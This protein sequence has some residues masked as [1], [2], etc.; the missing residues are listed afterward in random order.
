MGDPVKRADDDCE[1]EHQRLPASSRAPAAFERAVEIFKALGDESRLKTLEI[2]SRVPEAC[3]SELA[4]TFDEG[5]STVSHRLRLLRSAGLVARR[6]AGK[7][8]Y[9]SLADDHVARLVRDALEHAS[10]AD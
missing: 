2:L 8:V 5:V 7:H 10:E 3:V 1:G 9:Y 6:R 4:A